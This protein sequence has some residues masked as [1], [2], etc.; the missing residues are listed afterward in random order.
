[1]ERLGKLVEWN[2][3]RGY[4]FIVSIDEPQSRYFLHIH[5]YRR[6]GRRPEPGEILRF[7][8]EQQAD[9]R[10]R[11]VK[12]IRAV[13]AAHRQTRAGINQKRYRSSPLTW[14]PPILVF[15]FCCLLGSTWWKDQIPGIV[16]IAL[17]ILNPVTFIIYWID[18]R[19]A[20]VSA[21]RTAEK[22][23]H[24]LELLGGWPAAWLAQVLLRHKSRKENYRYVFLAAAITNLAT[25]SLFIYIASQDR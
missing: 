22:T 16:L 8:P 20:Q 5:E 2:D 1:M 10:W 6:M 23:L 9:G 4:G 21:R 3:E 11:A 18:K 19:A 13:S 12:V 15:A 24:L 14:L 17:A 25:L 7:V